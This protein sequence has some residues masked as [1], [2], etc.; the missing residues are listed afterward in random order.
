MVLLSPEWANYLHEAGVTKARLRAELFE[1][2]TCEWSKLPESVISAIKARVDPAV[3]GRPLRAAV[4]PDDIVVVVAGGVGI[5]QTILPNWP[6]SRPV[7]VP[8]G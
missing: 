5:K 7:T 4:S 8:V 6:G 1:R 2:A 3:F